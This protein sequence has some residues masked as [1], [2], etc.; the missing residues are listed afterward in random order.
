MITATKTDFNN[1]QIMADAGKE[2]LV[3]LGAGGDIQEWVK[4]VAG[5]LVDEG[6]APE[7]YE[8][9]DAVWV[10]TT[11][12]RTDLALTFSSGL[13]MG[14]LVIWRLAYG[15]CSW[16]SDYVVNY[17]TQHG[18]EELEPDDDYDDYS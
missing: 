5:V 13:V 3:M 6:I 15:D 10:N 14:K 2:A 11:G 7:G 18:L 12:G 9:D 16:L 4:G 8:F 17:R 1:L